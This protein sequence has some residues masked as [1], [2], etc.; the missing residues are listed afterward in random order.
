MLL[1]L[2]YSL[3]AGDS[4]W[5]LGTADWAGWGLGTADGLL[6]FRWL[7]QYAIPTAM[8]AVPVVL[9]RNLKVSSTVLQVGASSCQISHVCKYEIERILLQFC[10]G[11]Y[12]H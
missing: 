2:Y 3:L 11:R 9:C 4:G 7:L 5:G 12:R 10:K 8:P 6:V 1:L